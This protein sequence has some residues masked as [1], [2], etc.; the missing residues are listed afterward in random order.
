MEE[1]GLLTASGLGFA[2]R[3]SWQQFRVSR[4]F[5]DPACSVLGIRGFMMMNKKMIYYESASV[6]LSQCLDEHA[7]E[8]EQQKQLTGRVA[9]HLLYGGLPHNNISKPLA[10][11]HDNACIDDIY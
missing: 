6:D 2:C 3:Q 5:A 10:V 9:K 11:F 1:V 4:Y 7:E 8:N